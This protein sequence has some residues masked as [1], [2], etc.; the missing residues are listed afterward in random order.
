MKTPPWES[1]G[2][3][4]EKQI[5]I[6]NSSFESSFSYFIQSCQIYQIYSKSK[7][8]AAAKKVTTSG[9]RPHDYWIK[10]LMLIHLS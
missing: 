10:S 6:E 4:G 5:S 2:R 3:S 7:D 1:N 9:A 8:F